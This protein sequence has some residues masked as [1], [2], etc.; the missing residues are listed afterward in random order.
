M[1]NLNTFDWI[2]F[3]LLVIGGLNWGMVGI[4]NINLVS[5]LFGDMSTVARIVY[6]LVGISAVYSIYILSTKVE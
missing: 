6:D 3:V 5:L 4:F 2:V 1:K